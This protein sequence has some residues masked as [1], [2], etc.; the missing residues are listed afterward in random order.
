[1]DKLRLSIDGRELDGYKGQTILE[2]ALENGIEIPTF[3][4]DKRIATYGACSICVV[5]AEGIPKLLRA[6]ATDIADGMVI[7]TDTPRVRESRK[8]NLELLL[9]QHTGD[10]RPPCILACPAQTDCQGYVG[11]IANG[12]TEEALKL[13]KK[14][15]PLAAS[16]GRVCPH[17][18]EDA[19][20]RK[21]LEEPVS[22]LNLKRFAAD[23]D[24]DKPEPFLPETAPPTSKRVAVIGGGPGGLSCAFYLAEMGHSVTVFEAMPK[25]GGMLRYGIPEYRLPKVVVDK[26]AALIEKMGVT[27]KNNIRIG[28]D[29]TFES[30]QESHDAVII[31]IGAWKSLPLPCTGAELK[32][33]HGGIDFL[34]TAYMDTGGRTQGDGSLVLDDTGGRFSCVSKSVAVTQGDGSPVLVKVSPDNTRG[35]FS[36]VGKSVA[37]VGGGNTAMDACRTAVRLGAEK[38]YIIYRRTRAEMPAEDI[39]I[40]EAEEEGV[41]FK[42]LVNPLEIIEENGRAAKMRLQKMKLGEP[43]ASGRRRPVP[44]EGDEETI[45]VDMVIAALGQG[46]APEGFAGIKLTRGNTIIADEQAF[47]T[48]I[49]SVFAIGDCI[50]EGAS[51]AIKSIGD[52]KKAAIA[53]DGY[54]AG[55]ET[56]HKEPYRVTRDDL[57]EEDFADR[58]KEPRSQARHLSPGDRR[59]NFSEVKETFDKGTAIKEAARCLE[60]GCHDFFECK[61]IAYADRHD[62]EPDRFRESVPKVE[63]KDD[64][65][66]IL[67]DPNKCI[68][69]GLCVRVCEELVGSAALGFVERGFNTVVKPAFED[70]LS[71]TTCISCGQCVSAC[72]TGALQER[73]TIRKPVPLETNKTDTICGMCA[74]GCGT[75]IES[76]GDLIVKTV[77]AE[78]SVMC[79]YG[80]FGINYVQKDGRLTTPM[81]RKGGELKPASWSEAFE[82]T[83]KNIAEIKR[84]GEKIAVS[85][86]HTYCIEDAGAIVNLAKLLDAEAFS[87]MNRENGLVRVLGH[88]GSPNTLEEALGCDSIIVFGTS[89][90]KTPAILSKLRQA[91]KN[92]AHV[93]VVAADAAKPNLKCEVI[94]VPNS[95]ALIK[96]VIKALI[97]AGCTPQNADGFEALKASLSTTVAG[98]DAL[99]IAEGYKDAQR[100]MIF[101]ALD[102]LSAD[103]ATELAN[104]AV[105]AGHIGSP[106]NG[107]YML[108]QLSGSQALADYAVTATADAAKDCKGLMIF[109]EDPETRFEEQEYEFL[110]VQDIFMTET[111]KKADVVFPMAT[112]PEIDG[113]FINT[114]RRLQQCNKA[115][116]APVKYRTSEIA[117]KIAELLSGNAQAGIADKLY[118]NTAEPSP[119]APGSATAGIADKLY[120]NT[121]EP[122][123]CVLHPCVLQV[124]PESA[125][126]EGLIK[127]SSLKKAIELP[128]PK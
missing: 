90:L 105:V 92:G 62:V 32:G 43:D 28:Q 13:I 80:R 51:I 87:F 128:D 44:I 123:P 24:L 69:C 15:L 37:V 115:I 68:L 120:L 75:R 64:H 30:L 111:A 1:M 8:V 107:I 106:G 63:F 104:M 17:P 48:N 57:T 66:F 50:N 61:L 74:V 4:Y 73:I 71:E 58:K 3:C 89:L 117:Q 7:H 127:T 108:R 47:T 31:A 100:A 18:C 116:G 35:R 77:P 56:A 122:S 101:F 81:L 21:L 79:G 103:A 39:E 19:C 6:C 10:C 124:I 26:E 118:P 41:I 93:T 102:E 86:G 113:T 65:P 84:R 125:L 25:M 53:V 54:L 5:E 82:F 2:V 59:G 99:E 98:R 83:V 49:K 55:I 91:V 114:E 60:C 112:Y 16:I 94:I 29:M 76:V 22:I 78:N 34:R 126:F 95:T 46:I 14:K 85:I 52:A 38:V 33:V 96:Q 12:E 110:M 20:R 45:D 72:P 36:C 42:Y 27:F 109:G 119:C 11:L 23:I 9:S 70:P 88:D 40:T 67:R 97:D 121:A